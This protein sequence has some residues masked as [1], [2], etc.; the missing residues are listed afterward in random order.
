MRCLCSLLISVIITILIFSDFKDLFL[1]TYNGIS[2]S[3]YHNSFICETFIYLQTDIYSHS[4]SRYTTY[5][6]TL[7]NQ[8]G[9][10]CLSA[11][12]MTIPDPVFTESYEWMT[13]LFQRPTGRVWRSSVISKTYFACSPNG[14]SKDPESV[15]GGSWNRPLASCRSDSWTV[16]PTSFH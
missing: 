16:D 13:I 4:S 7:E 1:F 14:R 5:D 8:K 3:R 9:L 6:R 15:G 10:S 2:I 12:G 11:T